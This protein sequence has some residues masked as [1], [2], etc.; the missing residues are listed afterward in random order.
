MHLLNN[1]VQLAQCLKGVAAAAADAGVILPKLL[2]FSLVD[3]LTVRQC[4]GA[5]PIL[6]AHACPRTQIAGRA[7]NACTAGSQTDT[8]PALSKLAHRS[9]VSFSRGQ[10]CLSSVCLPKG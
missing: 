5:D 4:V 10:G 3:L 1:C 6:A 2:L 8:L 9:N 7:E